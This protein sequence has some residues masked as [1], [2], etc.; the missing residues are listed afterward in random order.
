M[1]ADIGLSYFVCLCWNQLLQYFKLENFNLF[2]SQLKFLLPRGISSSYILVSSMFFPIFL[3][4]QQPSHILSFSIH[5]LASNHLL[6]RPLIY[7][8]QQ[9]SPIPSYTIYPLATISYSVLYYLSYS[10]H[11]L[12]R[13]ILSILQQQSPIPSFNLHSLGTISFSVL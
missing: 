6:F 12:F 9:P 2:L 1:F 7:I 5:P 4:F 11:L 8:L 10:H 3:S 13:P